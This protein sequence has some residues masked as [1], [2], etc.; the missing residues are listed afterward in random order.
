MKRLLLFLLTGAILLWATAA[1]AQPT[2][3]MGLSSDN[4]FADY[5]VF[6]PGNQI[7]TVWVYIQDPVNPDFQGGEQPVSWINGF[8]C[9]VW[10]E[11]AAILLGWHF[12]VDAIDAGLNGNT[13]VGFAEPVPVVDGRAIVASLD[14]FLEYPGAVQLE[15]QASPLPCDGATAYVL[16][17]PTRPT[18]SI[19]GSMAYLDA[20]DPDN[21]LVAAQL[22]DFW[23]EDIALLMEAQPVDVDRQAWGGIKALYR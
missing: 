8:E 14:I 16:M 15:P 6:G 13:V 9:R 21:P 19:D 3:V 5:C 1:F 12:P 23:T 22:A 10:I 17:A 18:S 2:N 20:D 11:G 4:G 7:Y